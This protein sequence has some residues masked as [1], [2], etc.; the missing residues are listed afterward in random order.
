[1]KIALKDVQSLSW[2]YLKCL[3]ICCCYL[4]SQILSMLPGCLYS[5]RNMREADAILMSIKISGKYPCHTAEEKK[6]GADYLF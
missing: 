1:M 3:I 2:V 5:L 6:K 4:L